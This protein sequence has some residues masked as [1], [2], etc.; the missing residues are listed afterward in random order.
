MIAGEPRG[1][2]RLHLVEDGSWRC[3]ARA[4]S[5]TAAA[6]S[7]SMAASC[8]AAASGRMRAVDR[9][10]ALA[11]LLR[12]LVAPRQPLLIFGGLGLEQRDA[13]VDLLLEVGKRLLLP[14]EARIGRR[15]GDVDA[16][17]LRSAGLAAP[18]ARRLGR[19]AATVAACDEPPAWAAALPTA[20]APMNASR[21]GAGHAPGALVAR[22][23]RHGIGPTRTTVLPC[24]AVPRRHGAAAGG[25]EATPH[26]ARAA[27]RTAAAHAVPA[28]QARCLIAPPGPP[29]GRPPT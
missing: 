16:V 4:C 28:L 10:Q 5:R 21:R 23:G 29:A 8:S 26:A 22:L 24:P 7:S 14:G 1:L 13:L 17:L 18:A 15:V 11:R 19:A 27:A 6:V 2:R 25:N 20:R 12:E 9:H 3:A